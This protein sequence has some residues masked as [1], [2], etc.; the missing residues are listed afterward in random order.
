MHKLLALYTNEMIKISK[1]IS[2]FIIIGIM[3]LG[4]VGFGALMKVQD[5]MNSKSSIN[6]SNKNIQ[7]QKDDMSRQ[8]DN[9][10]AQI[11][12]I[13]KKKSSASGVELRKLEAEE[14]NAQNQLDMF[15]YA[16]DRDILANSA[17]YRAQAI[18]TLFGYKLT[19]SELSA[20]PEASLSGDQRKELAHAQDYALRLEKVIDNKDFKGFIS[21]SDD[22]IKNNTSLSSDD[23]KIALESNQLKLKYNQTGEVNGQADTTGGSYTYIYQIENGKRSL[24][25]NLDYTSNPQSPKP[26]T[27]ELRQ[28]VKNEIAVAEYKLEK[29]ITPS[30]NIGTD[31]KA[32]VMP[33][34]LGVGIFMIV[35][36]LMILAGGSVSQ[37]IST[38]SIKSLI[39]SPAKRWKIFVAKVASLL[40]IGIIAALILYVIAAIANGLFFGF[41]SGDPYIYASNGAAHELNFYIYQFARIFTD[42]IAVVVFMVF[43]LMLSV[44]TRNTAASVGISIAVYFVGNNANAILM[45]FVDG[46][47]RKFIPFNNLDFTSK[48]FPNDSLSQAASGMGVAVNNS[49]AFSLIYVAVLVFCMGYIALDSFNRRDIK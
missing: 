48:I 37:E 5:S 44:V 31:I 23:K 6:T 39:I 47:W 38:G 43:A 42:F 26:L 32:I 46:E 41:S 4:V 17:S 2:V 45:R 12:E 27:S 24:L 14:R 34:M 35:I 29:G 7:F 15:Q 9:L 16:K 13:K 20:V 36:L 1:K 19:I 25:S 8:I 10:K 11:D 28:K 3:I 40:T 33:G 18:Q 22:I 49:L 30:S 21:I